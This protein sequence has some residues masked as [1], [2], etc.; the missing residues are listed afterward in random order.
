MAGMV[1]PIPAGLTIHPE[2]THLV[3]F[4]RPTRREKVGGETFD[5][6]GFT[7]YWDKTRLGF[8]VIKRRTMKKRLR[9]T[10]RA[11]WVWCRNNRHLKIEHQHRVLCS[12]INGHNQYYGIRC[13]CEMLKIVYDGT[14]RAWRYWLSQRSHKS[15]IRWDKFKPQ[16][17]NRFP[18]PTPRVIHAI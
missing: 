15:N 14:L 11:L 12:K 9:R 4:R 16:V 7:H 17:L 2:K 5:L 13:N 8:W 3:N 10:L 18:L 1:S 6:L